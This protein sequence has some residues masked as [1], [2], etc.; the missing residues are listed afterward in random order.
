MKLPAGGVF[1]ILSGGC[2]RRNA[3]ICGNKKGVA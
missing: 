1:P 3:A 2:S